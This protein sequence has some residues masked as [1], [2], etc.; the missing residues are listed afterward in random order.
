MG[1]DKGYFS[2]DARPNGGFLR[3]PWRERV[4]QVFLR[5]RIP[6]INGGYILKD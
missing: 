6:M 1:D 5:N 4:K 2:L 3:N